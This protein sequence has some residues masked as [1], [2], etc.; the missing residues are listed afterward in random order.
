MNEYS[1]AKV[2]CSYYFVLAYDY[3]AKIIIII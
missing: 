1:L 3:I 2:Q